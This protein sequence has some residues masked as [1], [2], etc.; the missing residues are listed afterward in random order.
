ME[1]LLEAGQVLCH[2]LVIGEIAMGRLKNRGA[3]LG[4]LQ[5]LPKAIFARDDEVLRFISDRSFFGLGIG[6]IDAHLLAS[7]QVT[8][9]S[10]LW[11]RDRRLYQ[12]GTALSLVSEKLR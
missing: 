3:L 12:V 11:T 9:G 2:P 10:L 5:R 4:T 8:A 1:R 6:Y 7:V